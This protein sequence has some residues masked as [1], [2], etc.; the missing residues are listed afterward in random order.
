M[1][2]ERVSNRTH[3]HPSKSEINDNRKRAEPDTHHSRS[4]VMIIERVSNRTHTHRSSSES[5]VI[6]IERILNRTLRK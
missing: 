2:I 1:I 5:E 4:E 6:I 3:T